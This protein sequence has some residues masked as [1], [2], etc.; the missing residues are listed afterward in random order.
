MLYGLLGEYMEVRSASVHFSAHQLK[1]RFAVAPSDATTEAI[2]KGIKTELR[3][4]GLSEETG[5][6]LFVSNKVR[7]YQSSSDCGTSL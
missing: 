3:A 4:L 2:I 7:G 5:D 6:V 1:G